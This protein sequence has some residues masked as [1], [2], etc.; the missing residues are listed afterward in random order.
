[1]KKKEYNSKS[2]LWRLSLVLFVFS[3]SFNLYAQNSTVTGVV[4][5][6]AE[7]PLIGVSV[8]VV[9]TSTGT[10]TD[11]DGNFKISI[12][13]GASLKFSYM[14]Y[15][16]QE[17]KVASSKMRVILKEDSKM[18]DEVIIVGFGTMKKRDNAGSI[19]SVDAKAIEERNAVSVFDA[20]QGA[21]PGVSIT[22][23]S[24]APG[25]SKSIRVRGASTFE[26]G[27]VDP[28][29]VVD[30]VM[31]DDIDNL[32]PN[33]IKSMEILKDAASASIYGARSANGVI[34]ITTKS[35]EEGKPRVDFSYSRS[36]SSPTRKLPQVNAFESRLS[37]GAGDFD[38]AS[39]WLEKF[40]ARTDS[41][42][43]Q[44]S[45]NYY[46]QDLLFRTGSVDK[47]S[48]TISGGTKQATYRVSLGYDGTEGILLET[49]SK[50]YTGQLNVD[51]K[52]W[53]NVKFTTL[54]RLT[55]TKY[56]K[57]DEKTVLQGAMRRDPDMII[58]YPDGELIPYYSSGGRVNPIAALEQY[59]DE[60]DRYNFNFTQ[61]IQW[62][63][64]KWLTLNGT[65]AANY[66][67][68]RE[69]KFKSKY[70]MGK[71]TDPN[72]GGDF[73]TWRKNYTG[74]LYVNYNKT[75]AKNH[76]INA[77]LGAS[78]EEVST[79]DLRFEGSDFLSEELYTM[80]LATILNIAKTYTRLQ[81]TSAVGFFGRL[82]YSWKSRYILAGTLR[83]DA[84][85]KFGK[86]NRWGWFPSVSAAWR[87]SDEFFMKWTKPLLSDAK[88]RVSYGVTGN[89]KISAYEAMTT[90]TVNG[91]YNNIGAVVGSSKYGNPNLKWE[92]TKQTNF[93][94]D[95]SFLD[96]RIYF[97]GDYY[98][99]KTHDLLADQ[100]LPYTTGYDNIRVN[101]ASL[102]NRGLELSVTAVPVQTRAFS[103]TTTVNWWKNKNKIL[104][105]A[106]DD[107]VDSSIWLVAKGK[108]AGLW[109]GWK[110]TGVFE[111]DCSNAYTA[112]WKNRLTPVLK[113]DEHNN[114]IIGLDGQPTV[115]GY[116]NADGSE[117]HG[118][119]KKIK[120]NGT[121]ASGGDVIW[122]N[123]NEDGDI[124]ESDKQVLGKATPTW[125]ASWSN[126]LNYKNFSLSFQFYLSWG[127]KVYNDLKRYTTTWGGSS[128]KQ[129]PEYVLQ[130]WR[131]PGQITDW[132]ALNTRNRTTLNREQLNS[133]Y[134]EDGSF[135]RLQS[136]R[137]SYT[138]ER[139]WLAKTPFRNVQ[140]Y[141][142]GNQLLT[143]T[144]YTG[145]DPEVS[146][147]K[148]LTPG[149]DDSK[150]PH[151]RELGFGINVGF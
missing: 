69:S 123:L 121:V 63:L 148:V 27:G 132:Y 56:N 60:F 8:S 59:R 81:E 149:R 96:G 143:W 94:L 49:Y 97:T 21:A 62:N 29:Y 90:Y 68:Q 17:I 52:P 4:V 105:L 34:I 64:T 150:Y 41:C 70:L 98:I 129:H 61:K 12:K 87:V 125:Y 10:V 146:G 91:N 99:K 141:V 107:Y 42:G 51:F 79:D 57:A 55:N 31:V 9:G 54:A 16:D 39:K 19:T 115:L 120:H 103:W 102:E 45:T 130:G 118:E 72:T 89:D 113:R 1:M 142:Y 47:F 128:H 44:Y 43:L 18:L 92:E 37:M 147:N 6:E 145:Y 30:G 24:G 33:D 104:D 126:S 48:A 76:T 65:L 112:D 32:S 77:M 66:Q 136:I 133:Q 53:K 122:E 101:L 106:K 84:S 15:A 46:Y 11:L 82:N 13:K 25:E 135:L 109:Y 83:R 23:T 7:E 38:N 144:N 78:F 35:G 85:S 73:T 116:L 108:Q 86:N 111:Y 67:L 80:N 58:W 140:V 2:L 36:F 100:K 71:D 74:D 124:D 110:N 93:G 26:D 139:E 127:G 14:G 28:L 95:L 114:V 88:I 151:C 119:I 138:L 20:L 117:Y 131:Y 75:F 22:A 3:V 50:R 134:L 137:L 5:D 40:S